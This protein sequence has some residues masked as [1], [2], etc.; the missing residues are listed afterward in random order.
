MRSRKSATE[1]WCQARAVRCTAL[2]G[3][4]R[5][6][7]ATIRV[8]SVPGTCREVHGTT[9][10][11]PGTVSRAG[12]H[13]NR[14]P[15]LMTRIQMSDFPLD[16][17]AHVRIVRAPMSTPSLANKR[18]ATHMCMHKHMSFAAPRAS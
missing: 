16:R 13:P 5:E 2:R 10:H 17:S 14:V 8:F 3:T 18:H 12:E 15:A 11:V 9:R 1:G 7:N 6:R 4:C